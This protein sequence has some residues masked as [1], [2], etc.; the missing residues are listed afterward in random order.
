M[1]GPVGTQ[2]WA[3][4]RRS[5][6]R[7]A[8]QPAV[9]FFSLA[10][11]LILLAITVSALNQATNLPGFPTDSYLTF[12]LGFTFVQAGIY[13]VTNAGTELALDIQ[14]G[15]LSRL[16]LTPLRGAALLAGFLAGAVALAIVQAIVFLVVGVAA[17]ADVA[18][19]PGGVLVLI[20][21]SA[22]LGLGFGAVGLF[23]ALRSGDGRSMQALYPVLLGLIFF[24][25]S[26]LPRDL[27][28]IDWFR[29][30]ATYNPVSY[31]I[32]A[33]RSLLISGWDAEALAL[34]FGIAI[35]VAVIG[36]ALSSAA[37][38]TRLVRT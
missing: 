5:M 14:T 33:S 28:E 19:G 4:A 27:I 7:T 32:E 37:L 22:L 12:I 9:I 25:S 36:L 38:R 8:R 35:A 30:V 34:G 11:P 31:L 17:G 21:F 23:G 3:L 2:A 13:A 24:S 6:L 26:L 1:G 15:F 10:F 16:S 18:A 29:E 20:G